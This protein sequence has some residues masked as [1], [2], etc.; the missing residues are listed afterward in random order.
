MCIGSH[1][2]ADRCKMPLVAEKENIVYVTRGGP[3][4]STLWAVCGKTA[5][6]LYANMQMEELT[7]GLGPKENA[8]KTQGVRRTE[9]ARVAGEGGQLLLLQE[10]RANS[11][12]S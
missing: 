1:A 12:P 2:G 5:A 8:T 4:Y 9:A 10:R 3:G 6:H 11:F 7:A